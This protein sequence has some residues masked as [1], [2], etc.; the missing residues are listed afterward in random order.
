L[1]PI[2]EELGMRLAAGIPKSAYAGVSVGMQLA[3]GAIFVW[4]GWAKAQ[5][6][7]DFLGDIYSYQIAGAKMGV[8]IAMIIPF[9]ELLV[10]VCLLLRIAVS[11]SLIV[12]VLLC[13]IFSLAQASVLLR[14]LSIDCGCFG[15]ASSGVVTYGTLVRVLVM[16]GT[17]IFA[18][19]YCVTSGRRATF[20]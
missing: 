8:L 6:P 14:G 15:N 1:K 12:A 18:Y 11:G 5:A 17:S 19:A 13:S 4:S 10:G 16:L 2:D 20:S 9:L 7:F 3:L